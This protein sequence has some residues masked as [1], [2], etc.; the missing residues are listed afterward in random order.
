MHGTLLTQDPLGLAGGVNLYAYAGNSPIRF[1]DPF[2]LTS[3]SLRFKDGAA[4]AAFADCRA[5]RECAAFYNEVNAMADINVRLAEDGEVLPDGKLTGWTQISWDPKT[6]VITGGTI[7]IQP[8]TFAQVA[9]AEGVPIT[10]LT[11]TS[12]ELGHI[13]GT[14]RLPIGKACGEKCT[15][16]YFENPVRDAAK[17]PRRP[18]DPAIHGP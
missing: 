9:E 2:G 1:R 4:E 14:S 17:L 13:V 12:H 18:Y 15:I 16:N 6:K 10:N 5:L 7:I 11:T 3:D 8:Q